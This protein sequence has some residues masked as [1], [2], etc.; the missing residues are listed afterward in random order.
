M[1]S[2]FLDKLIDRMDRVEPGEVQ[3]Y[4]IQLSREKGFL[5]R[6][7][8]ALQ[9]GVIILNATGM[10]TYLNGAA[11]RIFGLPQDNTAIGKPLEKT[12]LGLKWESFAS[13]LHGGSIISRDL[14]IFYPENRFL[15]F[16]LS[17]VG[18]ESGAN[19]A[20][21]MLIRDI[22]HS[23]KATEEKIESERLSALT[24][25]AAGVAHELGNPLNSLNIH[26][27]LMRRKLKQPGREDA[28]T[29]ELTDMLAVAEGEISR[30]DAIIK[31]VLGAVRPTRPN[32][33]STRLNRLLRDCTRFL[34]PELEDRG[35]H[36]NLELDPFLP[37]MALDADQLK[38]A[39]FNLIRNASQAMIRGDALTIS[40][41][42]DDE[43]IRVA[44]IDVGSGMSPEELGAA[45]EPYHTTKDTG[46]G[47]GLLVVRR[48]VREHGGE[49]E[50]KSEQGVGT[51]VTIHLPRID[52]RMRFLGDG[53]SHRDQS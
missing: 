32:L 13:S 21:V 31:Q 53:Q 51:E 50:I 19:I 25:L 6:V 3:N 34:N 42:V 8:E 28:T 7:F 4:L 41:E 47:L 52:K 36:I 9:E 38:Q 46:T 27:Q 40:T 39:F 11:Q 45:F 16:Y 15:N 1:K 29:R 12:I 22:T 2:G 48:I 30:L 37:E 14:E 18:D 24:L 43:E 5:E 49:I 33:S 23:R 10:V 17:P 20:F 26:L 44:F 35:I